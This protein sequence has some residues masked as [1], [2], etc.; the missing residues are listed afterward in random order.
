MRQKSKHFKHAIFDD[1]CKDNYCFPMH[2]HTYGFKN[3]IF[4]FI[5]DN[6]FFLWV[7]K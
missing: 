2:T 4:Y 3:V 1:N 5:S 7:K 6:F